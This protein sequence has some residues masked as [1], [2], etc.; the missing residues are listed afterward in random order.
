MLKLF[1]GIVLLEGISFLTLIFV[2]MPLKYI[3][4][5]PLPNKI[6]GM[7]HGILTI[8]YVLQTIS[9]T[10]EYSLS[11]KK[12]GIILLGSLIPFGSFYV[13]KTILKKIKNTEV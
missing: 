13:D 4:L 6:I 9:I 8:I 5:L 2:T 3:F 7:I 12:T 11:M 10:I 1:R